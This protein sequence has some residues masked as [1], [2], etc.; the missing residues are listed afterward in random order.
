MLKCAEFHGDNDDMMSTPCLIMHTSPIL[1]SRAIWGHHI[2]CMCKKTAETHDQPEFH[3]LGWRGGG[4]GGGGER[5][6]SPTS[7][8]NSSTT[9]LTIIYNRN[10]T[11][12][13]FGHAHLSL[14]GVHIVQGVPHADESV[15]RVSSFVRTVSSRTSNDG[16][17]LQ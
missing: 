9:P 6:N 4:G 1:L 2:V 12:C 11:Y 16:V 15:C 13:S 8:P 3:L 14:L 10:H 5:P 7:P 17:V